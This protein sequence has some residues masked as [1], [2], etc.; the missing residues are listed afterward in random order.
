M[1]ARAHACTHARVRARI[2]THMWGSATSFSQSC[3]THSSKLT[4]LDQIFKNSLEQSA[5]TDIE[6]CHLSRA[7][8]LTAGP[9]VTLADQ[10]SPSNKAKKGLRFKIFRAV[11]AEQGQLSR[12]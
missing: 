3:A 7:F 6:E 8:T 1:C 5:S 12:L 2:H 9:F 4:G 11:S 10:Q